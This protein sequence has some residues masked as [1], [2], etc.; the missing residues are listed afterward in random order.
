[1]VIFWVLVIAALGAKIQTG[2]GMRIAVWI[3]GNRYALNR[4][5]SVIRRCLLG[6][7]ILLI[8]WGWQL[9]MNAT[10]DVLVVLVGSVLEVV[11]LYIPDLSVHVSNSLDR[12]LGKA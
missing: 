7:A 5:A 2:E 10:L 4:Q 1:M 8:W 6:L 3:P 11:A 12:L 9:R